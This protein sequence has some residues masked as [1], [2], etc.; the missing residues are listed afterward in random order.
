MWGRNNAANS[1]LEK[2]MGFGAP[3]WETK[4]AANGRMEEGERKNEMN[5]RRDGINLGRTKST[6]EEEEGEEDPMGQNL[7]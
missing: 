7:P 5:G 1:N 4:D 6:Q 2:G 3:F